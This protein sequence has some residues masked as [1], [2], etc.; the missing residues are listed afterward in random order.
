MVPENIG[1]LVTP[2]TF[3]GMYEIKQDT[4]YEEL[5]SKGYRAVMALIM[6]NTGERVAEPVSG[7]MSRKD[8]KR[9]NQIKKNAAADPPA[10]FCRGRRAR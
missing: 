4:S 9:V 2:V 5:V 8:E 6:G 1:R 10:W 7:N 3:A